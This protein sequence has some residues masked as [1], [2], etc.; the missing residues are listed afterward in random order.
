MPDRGGIANKHGQHVP[1]Q[2]HMEKKQTYVSRSSGAK[3][4]QQIS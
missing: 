4:T 3:E 2:G 1:T